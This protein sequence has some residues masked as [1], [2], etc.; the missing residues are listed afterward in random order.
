MFI[1]IRGDWACFTAPEFKVERYSYPVITPEAAE[2]ILKSVFWKPEIDY[3]VKKIYV[4]KEGALVS[5]GVTNERIEKNGLSKATGHTQRS[6]VWLK[7]VEYV[8]EVEQV[9]YEDKVK[10]TK[11]NT[12]KKYE[13][14]LR[15]RLAK[16][17]YFKAPYLGISACPVKEITEVKPSDIKP[18]KVNIV[19][20]GMVLRIEYGEQTNKTRFFDAVV[21]EGVMEVP[22]C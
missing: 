19:V 17:K 15:K 16:G 21:K 22:A 1:K 18:K 6:N 8:L 12:V 7:D 20:P 2:N 3:T 10:P 4:I 9:I 13:A 11:A 14:M 5:V